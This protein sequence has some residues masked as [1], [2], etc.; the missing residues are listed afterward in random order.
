MTIMHKQFK[1]QDGCI[2][3]S[4][5]RGMYQDEMMCEKVHLYTCTCEYC[6]VYININACL[7]VPIVLSTPLFTYLLFYSTVRLFSVTRGT[8]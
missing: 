4:T 3:T 2:P 6:G 7:G 8:A 1:R 5:N